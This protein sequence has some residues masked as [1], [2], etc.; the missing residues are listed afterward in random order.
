MQAKKS[1]TAGEFR[2]ISLYYCFSW[3]GRVRPKPGYSLEFLSHSVTN[4]AYRYAIDG[5]GGLTE[6]SLLSIIG[7]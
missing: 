2:C 6:M 7:R 4:P 1:Q 3:N 5:I